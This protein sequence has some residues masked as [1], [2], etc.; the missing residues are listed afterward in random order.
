MN[1]NMN[2]KQLLD[3]IA[4]TE[5]YLVKL[6]HSLVIKDLHRYYYDHQYEERYPHF[7]YA[8][9][10]DATGEINFYDELY[11]VKMSQALVIKDLHR[12]FYDHQWEKRYRHF[13]YAEV[14]DDE[15]WFWEEEDEEVL[16]EIYER[17]YAAGKI[18]F[19]DYIRIQ[20]SKAPYFSYLSPSEP[21]LQLPEGTDPRKVV[22]WGFKYYD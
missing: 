16:D 5:L 7:R 3:T 15:A 10:D 21:L 19:H 4:E 9:V 8:E 22:G 20:V 13:R 2:H 6:K 11:L 1:M 12:Y 17:N 18:V 14:D